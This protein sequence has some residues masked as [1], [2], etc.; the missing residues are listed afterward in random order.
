MAFTAISNLTEGVMRR[1]LLIALLLAGCAQLPPTA[2][3]IQ[4]KKFIALPDASVIYVVRAGADSDEVSGLSFDD[5]PP[6]TTF[7]RTY[8][9]WEVAPG[10]H[11]IAGYASASE[12]VTL[13][14]E[15]GKIYFLKHTVW[16]TRRSGA[17][18]TWLQQIGEREG[19]ALVLRAQLLQ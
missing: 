17:Q 7:R 10:R 6:I 13:T 12:S 9:R 5:Q 1:I 4:A 15:P 14:T 2:E 11:R 3:D 19:R 16:G 8:Y 18:T